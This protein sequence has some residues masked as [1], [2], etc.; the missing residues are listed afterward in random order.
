MTDRDQMVSL[1]TAAQRLGVTRQTIS[2]R[3]RDRNLDERKF[4][5]DRHIYVVLSE[6]ADIPTRRTA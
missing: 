6:V 4:A 3:V 1:E 5:G 2:N